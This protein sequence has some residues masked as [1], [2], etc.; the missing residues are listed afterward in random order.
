M[1]RFGMND[2]F[3]MTTGSIVK[4][5]G[6]GYIAGKQVAAFWF[7]E[8]STGREYTE[9]PGVFIRAADD[10][11]GWKRVERK[12]VTTVEWVDVESMDDGEP[13]ELEW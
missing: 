13:D 7:V 11:Y 2:H 8:D 1:R 12:E 4:V 3:R 5:G 10:T 6:T 9:I